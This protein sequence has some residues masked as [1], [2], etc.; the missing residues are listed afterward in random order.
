MVDDWDPPSCSY[1]FFPA[2]AA[3][4]TRDARCVARVGRGRFFLCHPGVQ[5]TEIAGKVL[6]HKDNQYVNVW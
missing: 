5:T 4:D 2:S 6:L 1:D 3:R